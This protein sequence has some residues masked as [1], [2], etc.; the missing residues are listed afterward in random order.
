MQTNG[1]VLVWVLSCFKRELKSEKQRRQWRQAKGFSPV[2]FRTWRLSSD[3]VQKL[4]LHNLQRYTRSFNDRILEILD[5]GCLVRCLNL[6][7]RIVFD[8]AMTIAVKC[9]CPLSLEVIPTLLANELPVGFDAVPS[10][11]SGFW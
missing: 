10:S 11:P 2:C 8:A 3:V 9:E 5:T 1:R 7:A 4:S 6:L